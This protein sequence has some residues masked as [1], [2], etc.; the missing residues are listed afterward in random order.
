[1]SRFLLLSCLTLLWAGTSS[2][3]GSPTLSAAGW[4]PDATAPLVPD[5]EAAAAHARAI[6]CET[7]SCKAIIVID[8]LLDIMQFED[9]DANGIASLHVGNRPDI[10]G[11]RL[12]RTLLD[13]PALYRPVCATATKLISRVHPEMEATFVPVTLLL[14]GVDMDLRD[15]GHCAGMLVRA[16]PRDQGNDQIRMNARDA[17][18]GGFENHR[19]PKAACAVLVQ[20]VDEKAAVVRGLEP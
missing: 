19:R 10:A 3:A 2:A 12:D 8:K 16:L 18:I 7:P 14:N 17:C 15:H 11:H 4:D 20:G 1:M 9:G 5:V 13:H 6:D